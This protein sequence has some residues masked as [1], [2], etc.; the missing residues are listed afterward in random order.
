[1]EHK[2]QIVFVNL[3][4][5]GFLLQFIFIF[6]AVSI[7][8]ILPRQRTNKELLDQIYNQHSLS[9]NYIRNLKI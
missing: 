8:R 6:F 4:I 2:W 9:P 7:S 1:M 3:S 5:L